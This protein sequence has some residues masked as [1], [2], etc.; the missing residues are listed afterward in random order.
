[1]GHGDPASA[2]NTLY[3]VVASQPQTD[4][5]WLASELDHYAD[6]DPL[7]TTDLFRALIA[8]IDALRGR[9][10]PAPVVAARGDPDA[11]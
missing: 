7:I 11:R 1:M 8:R 5:A 10:D 6:F 3:K 9:P 2:C 4:S